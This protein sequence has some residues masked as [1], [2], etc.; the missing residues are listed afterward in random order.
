M[1]CGFDAALGDPLGECAVT[2]FGYSLMTR[3]L[4]SLAG[5]RLVLAQEGGYNLTVGFP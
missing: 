1:S 4:M 3:M 5:G 2:P